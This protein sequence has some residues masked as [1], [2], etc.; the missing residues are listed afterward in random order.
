MANT[1][2]DGWLLIGTFIFL[3]FAMAKPFGRWLYALYEGR[4][5][6]GLGW[7][8]PVERLMLSL[9]GINP[10]QEQ[11]WVGYAVGLMMFNLAGIALL[12]AIQLLQGVLPL[13]PQGLGAVPLPVAINTAVSFVTNTNWQSYAGEATMSNFTQMAGLVVQNFLSA[14]TGIA[15]AFALIRG[16]ARKS[17]KTLGNFWADLTRVTLYILL[18]VPPARNTKHKHSHKE[19]GRP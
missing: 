19:Q 18:P 14:A 9:S 6:R 16:F 17:S 10:K 13:N 15:V 5:P 1:T 2:L 12:L 4:I 8:Q 7:L 3:T 11:S